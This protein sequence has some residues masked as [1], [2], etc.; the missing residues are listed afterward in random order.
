MS[1]MLPRRWTRSPAL[2]LGSVLLLIL[3]LQIPLF[4]VS[5][6]IEERGGRQEEVLAGIRRSW[7][8]AQTMTGVTLAI[9][10]SWMDP[11]TRTSPAERRE[12]WVRVPAQQL[13]I[14][15]ALTPETRQRGLFRATVYTAVVKA[16]GRVVVPA[17][18]MKDLSGVV[19]NWQGAILTL[20]ATDLRGQPAGET[21]TVN[22]QAV[23]MTVAGGG[24]GECDATVSVPAGFTGPVP[25]GTSL[26]VEGRLRLRGTQGFGIAPWGERIGLV[27]HAPWQTPS[28]NGQSPL[29][30]TVAGTGFE[31]TWDAS[32]NALGAGWRRSETQ[33]PGCGGLAAEDALSVDLLDAVPTYL[34]VTRAAKYGTLFL[35]LSFLT[36]FLIEQG[37]GVR[38]HIAQYALLG[39][40]VSLFALLLVSLA[41]P[42]GF[43]VGYL[44]STAAVLA[45]SSLYTLAVTRSGRL[46]GTFAGLLGALFGVLFVIIRLESFALLAGTG[47]LFLI[48]SAVMVAT[49]RLDWS[50][51]VAEV[52]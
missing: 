7:G 43:T 22:G 32:G 52:E 46:A 44:L 37:T 24:S 45:Q 40:S 30:Y 4:A 6:V 29:S 51:R 14:D 33:L 34:T 47:T 1:D 13:D 8:P 11:A 38:I 27:V 36:Y 25:A 3:V 28:F 16:A 23:P 15:A 2:K 10:Y 48:L 42:L 26:D 31:A 39:L 17:I 49:R 9:P 18:D 19:L 50:G 41:E 5:G 12:G 20:G 21:M 35:A